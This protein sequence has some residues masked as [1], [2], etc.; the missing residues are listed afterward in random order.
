VS[1]KFSN[2]SFSFL[3]GASLCLVGATV[4]Q[5]QASNSCLRDA[6]NRQLISE[7]SRRLEGG[8]G[9]GDPTRVSS[10][11]DLSC[12]NTLADRFG[13]RPNYETLL[14]WAGQCRV[15]AGEDCRLISAASNP[16]CV[17]NLIAK[18]GFR[19]TEDQLGGFSQ[20]CQDRTYSCRSN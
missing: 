7:L 4:T 6:S 18:F 13:Y 3:L 1:Q 11:V 17:D 5:A 19:P 15:T 14:S 12:V 9:G 10:S 16:T 2:L 20:A 8:N